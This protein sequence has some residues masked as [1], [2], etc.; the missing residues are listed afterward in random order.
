[1]LHGLPLRRRHPMSFA[2]TVNMRGTNRLPLGDGSFPQLPFAALGN[3]LH[4]VPFR[5]TQPAG[6]SLGALAGMVRAS[7]DVRWGTS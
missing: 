2:V 6:S 3:P 4:V 1:M 5:D 7:L